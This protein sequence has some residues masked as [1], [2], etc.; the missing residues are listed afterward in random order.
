M[1]TRSQADLHEDAEDTVYSDE[2]QSTAV[3]YS[4]VKKD[5]RSSDISRRHSAAKNQLIAPNEDEEERSSVNVRKVERSTSRSSALTRPMEVRR[6]APPSLPP[7]PA[8]RRRSSSQMTKSSLRRSRYKSVS[9]EEENEEEEEDDFYADD[10]PGDRLIKVTRARSTHVKNTRGGEGRRLR[11]RDEEESEPEEEDWRTVSRT[12]TA[13]DYSHDEAGGVKRRSS[14]GG[15]GRDRWSDRGGSLSRTGG[16]PKSP[17]A[18]EEG[19]SARRRTSASI[20][21]PPRSSNSGRTRRQDYDEEGE[22]E[23]RRW[24]TTSRKGSRDYLDEYDEYEEEEDYRRRRGGR[25]EARD[26]REAADDIRRRMRSPRGEEEERGAWRG[27]RRQLSY[28][29]LNGR[30][31]GGVEEEEEYEEEPRR[32]LVSRSGSQAA[33]DRRGSVAVASGSRRNS[34]QVADIPSPR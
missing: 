10:H 9:E 33:Y 12:S 22:K 24:T 13:R 19:K 28:A 1:Q 15:G 14:Q 23:P 3:V 29:S 18:A 7:L 17:P 26:Y 4:S 20:E 2:G 32:R 8:E 25:D 6:K 34:F 21:K 16:R 30:Y 5:Q 31:N 11:G 27:S